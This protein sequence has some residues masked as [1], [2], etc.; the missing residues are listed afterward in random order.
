ME[1][2]PS[3]SRALH[4]VPD[5]A[6]RDE[7]I[8]DLD[9][10]EG[11]IALLLNLAREQ[12]VDLKQISIL[13]LAEQYLAFIADA[14]LR[15]LELAG[16]YLVMAAWLAYLKSRLLLP[17]PP[18]DDEPSATELA[19]ALAR[20]LQRL[21]AMQR[22]GTLL[23]DGPQLGRE[24]FGRG[25]PETMKAVPKITF[26]A[27]VYELLT[28][29]AGHHVRTTQAVLRIDPPDYYSVDDALKRLS[30][31]VGTAVEWRWLESFMPPEI[32]QRRSVLAATFAASLELAK[33]GRIEL[34]QD[35]AFGPILIRAART[36]VEA[37]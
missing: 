32:A 6:E 29:Y 5:I 16:D 9:G 4:I 10:F 37:N 21:Q 23:M 8:L 35:Q 28:A 17:E 30:M 3:I 20:R 33:S 25:A 22:A 24:V 13:A 26:T 2:E 36:A 1:I 11:P 34:R 7:L 31:L 12:R 15:R 27:S 19:E 14:R 18:A